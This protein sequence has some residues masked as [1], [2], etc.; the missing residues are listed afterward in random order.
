[1]P[2]TSL[3]ACDCAK[4]V[5]GAMKSGKNSALCAADVDQDRSQQSTGEFC[6]SRQH[7]GVAAALNRLDQGCLRVPHLTATHKNVAARSGVISRD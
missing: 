1:M 5:D 4:F 2:P 3:L 7:G 6:R